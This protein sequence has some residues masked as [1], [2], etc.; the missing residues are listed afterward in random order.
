MGSASWIHCWESGQ[1]G[2]VGEPPWIS[3][4]HVFSISNC[5]FK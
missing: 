2:M 1:Q 3:Q 5:S 4:L